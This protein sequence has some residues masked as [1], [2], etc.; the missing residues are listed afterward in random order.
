MSHAGEL[1]VDVLVMVLLFH[2]NVFLIRFPTL[3]QAYGITGVW[4]L[5]VVLM[6]IINEAKKHGHGQNKWY[7]LYQ[8][9]IYSYLRMVATSLLLLYVPS[10]AA[11]SI[12]KGN[13]NQQIVTWAW[14]LCGSVIVFFFVLRILRDYQLIR[15]HRKDKEDDS[16]KALVFSSKPLS[17]LS[18]DEVLSWVRIGIM[19]SASYFSEAKR[20]QVA[21]KLETACVDGKMLSK[22]GADK[23]KLVELIGLPLGDAKKLSQELDLLTNEND[24][25]KVTTE[26]ALYRE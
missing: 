5:A 16:I 13:G 15:Q 11:Y 25:T 14:A 8:L 22:Y 17:Q 24:I 9:Q 6:L 21:E 3:N 19:K 18:H 26:L 4:I 23:E 1:V 10:L 2:F 12:D 7:A 20:L